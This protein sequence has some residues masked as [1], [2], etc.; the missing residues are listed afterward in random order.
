MRF[1]LPSGHSRTRVQRA[2][3]FY[4]LGYGDRLVHESSYPLQIRTYLREERRFLER[5]LSSFDLL[6][7]VGCMHGRYLPWAAAREK[8][9]LGIDVVARYI[10][11]GL[12]IVRRHNLDQDRYKLL[13]GDAAN[14]SPAKAI[15]D[16]ARG[17][18]SLVLMPFNSFGNMLHPE[19]VLHEL[20]RHRFRFVISSY[21]TDKVS[22]EARSKYYRSSGC[23]SLRVIEDH[24]GVLFTSPNGLHA[25]A[26]HQS[27][28]R[29]LWR[30]HG[31]NVSAI[32]LGAIG[33]AYF[34]GSV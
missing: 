17:T 9:Y 25:Q 11:Q 3:A 34:G 2:A 15:L 20:K 12:G 13:L 27:Y 19:D 18:T 14:L 6:V 4:S 30:R 10:D 32:R 31:L 29:Q 5:L 33:V 23:R 8:S 28:L 21:H 1:K 22:T 24:S 16:Q 26:Y 7:E